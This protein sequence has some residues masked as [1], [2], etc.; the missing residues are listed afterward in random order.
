M[1]ENRIFKNEF[2]SS[3]KTYCILKIP[4]E[5]WKKLKGNK[6]HHFWNQNNFL[7]LNTM[8][9]T[10]LKK[11]KEKKNAA[12]YSANVDLK[13][14]LTTMQQLVREMRPENKCF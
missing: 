9:P 1:S 10:L 14:F 2:S 8:V 12:K 13:I 11:R 6:I 4:E 3:V 5:A 7:H